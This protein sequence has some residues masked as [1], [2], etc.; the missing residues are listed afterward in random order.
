MAGGVAFIS[1]Q[2]AV[3][4]R[5][6]SV[7]SRVEGPMIRWRL[8]C[9]RRERAEM[10]KRIDT[11]TLAVGQ[12]SSLST[13]G[14]LTREELRARIVAEPPLISEWRDLDAQLQPNGF[15]FTVA[16]IARI[17][18]A[19]VVGVDNA[20]RILPALATLTLDDDGWIDLDA[21][22]YQLIFNEIID[23]PLDLMALARPRSTLNRCGVTI[24][25][26]VWDCGY[27]GRS[28]ALLSVLN[29]AGFR[30]QQ[31]A[32]VMQAVFF[33]VSRPPDEGY[34]GAYQ[35]ENLSR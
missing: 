28:T 29:P 5:S 14:V 30:L 16:E 11:A 17:D 15:D 33:T 23:L 32:R 25:T 19:G 20:D 8:G 31:H 3:E 10:S 1:G 4:R 7:K 6:N 18:E 12:Y 21:G 34:K 26:A 9:T 13:S 35:G 27:R 24:H 2:R 22:T